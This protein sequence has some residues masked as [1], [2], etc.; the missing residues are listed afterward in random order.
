MIPAWLPPCLSHRAVIDRGLAD[1]RRRIDR[2]G[3]V[4]LTRAVEPAGPSARTRSERP[5]TD[6][7][8][9]VVDITC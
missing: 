2:R 1:W 4:P 8:G 9:G 5:D 6:E 7:P 3:R